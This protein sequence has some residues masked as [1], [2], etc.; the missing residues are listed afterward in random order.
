MSAEPQLCNAVCHFSSLYIKF[1]SLLELSLP[2]LQDSE[3]GTEVALHLV[4]PEPLQLLVGSGISVPEASQQEQGGR[5]TF[6]HLSLSSTLEQ[7]LRGGFWQVPG[8]RCAPLPVEP[9]LSLFSL[10]TS[11]HFR[12]CFH[13]PLLLPLLREHETPAPQSLLTSVPL[14]ITRSLV[15]STPVT[16][17]QPQASHSAEG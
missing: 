13:P 1:F 12:F 15:Q 5:V 9:L 17:W 6:R 16:E 3:K 14:P 11:S 2:L 10:S 7:E 8:S 4:G